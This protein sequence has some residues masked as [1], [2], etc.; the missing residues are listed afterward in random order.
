MMNFGVY[1]LTYKSVGKYLPNNNIIDIR[2][3]ITCVLDLDIDRPLL[4]VAYFIAC[5]KVQFI[6]HFIY[7][8]RT[9]KHVHI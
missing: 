1:L 8:S 3:L 5:L 9:I 2:Y 7:V 4:Y 6:S